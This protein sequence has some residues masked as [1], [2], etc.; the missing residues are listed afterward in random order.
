M[1]NMIAD[2]SKY[3]MILLIAM[4]T[5]WNFRY[6]GVREERK[7]VLSRRQNGIMYLLHFLAYAV[8]FLKTEDVKLLVFYVAQVVFFVCYLFLYRRF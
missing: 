7:K 4:Y 8:M 1:T 2:I 6:F 3:L 5:Y